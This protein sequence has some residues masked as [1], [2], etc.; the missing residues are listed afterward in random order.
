MTHEHILLELPAQL[1]I[2][3]IPQSLAQ[4]NPRRNR[5]IFQRVRCVFRPPPLADGL[6]KILLRYDLLRFIG[7]VLLER[8]QPVRHVLELPLGRVRLA[9]VRQIGQVVLFHPATAAKNV[10]TVSYRKEQHTPGKGEG[11]KGGS[12]NNA[13]EHVW[14]SKGHPARGENE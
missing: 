7:P 5:Q 10:K 9:C 3:R 14:Q 13:S 8:G 2:L 1:L 12:W 11:R 4:L 6:G